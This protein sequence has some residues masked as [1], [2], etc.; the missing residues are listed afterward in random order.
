[1]PEGGGRVQRLDLQF[2]AFFTVVLCGVTLALLFDLLRVARGFL[3]PSRLQAAIADLLFW[4]VATSAV[5]GGLLAANWAELRFYVLVGILF[6]LG[7]YY[8]LASKTVVLVA[9]LLLRVMVW[10]IGLAADMCHRLIWSPIA[11]VGRLVWAALSAAW[12]GVLALAWGISH[13]LYR[14]AQW[15]FRPFRGIRRCVRLYY[16][17]TKRRWR[18]R[19]RP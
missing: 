1:V 5:T 12:G 14:L 15:L 2:Y 8:W 4:L 6:G 16:L 9:R 11:A 10:T 3:R 7:L 19:I 13:V 17:L 18:R